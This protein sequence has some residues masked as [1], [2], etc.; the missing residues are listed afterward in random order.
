MIIVIIGVSG[1]GKTTIGQGVAEALDWGFSDADDFH[2]PA[3]V[4]KMKSGIPLT[5][6]DREPWL[7]DLRA[8]IERWKRSEAGHVLACSALK[9][10]YREILGQNDP[11]VKFVYLRGAFDLI[12]RRLMERKGHFFDPALLRSQ[13]EALESPEDAMV[14][15][16]SN[17]PQEI[18]SSILATI[19]P[20]DNKEEVRR[21]N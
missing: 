17:K 15:N 10:S 19:K 18:I 4:R 21:K 13:F 9:E 16:I 20:G 1:S 11:D 6:E 3:N 2:S 7:R 8:A 14:F 12:A 5:D